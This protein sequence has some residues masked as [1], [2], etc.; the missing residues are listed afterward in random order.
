MAFIEHE[1]SNVN[2]PNRDQSLCGIIKN[3]NQNKKNAKKGENQRFIIKKKRIDQFHGFRKPAGQKNTF[4][5]TIRGQLNP[6]YECD[7]LKKSISC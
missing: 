4:H 5:D 2:N 1:H 3:G 6:R 7:K